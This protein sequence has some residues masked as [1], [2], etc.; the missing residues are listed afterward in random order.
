[1]FRRMICSAMIL[2]STLGVVATASSQANAQSRHLVPTTGIPVPAPLP[3]AP[4]PLPGPGYVG[5]DSLWLSFSPG[6]FHS[7]CYFEVLIRH[8]C[9]WDVYATVRDAREAERLAR[10]LR[11][12]GH[13]VRIRRVVF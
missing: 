2:A 9:H 6:Y 1:M 12:R 10:R 5:V 4:L 7:Y 11:W 8:D 3:I 13:D